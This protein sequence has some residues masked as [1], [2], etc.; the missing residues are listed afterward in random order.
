MLCFGQDVAAA[1]AAAHE[2]GLVHGDLKADNVVISGEPGRAKLLDFGLSIPEEEFGDGELWGTPAYMAPELLAGGARTAAA[3]RFALGVMLFEMATGQLPFGGEDGDE[4]R[5]RARQ[6]SEAPDARELR[7]EL[8]Q[9]I[10]E[11][12]RRLLGRDLPEQ[13]PEAVEVERILRLR[14]RAEEGRRLQLSPVLILFLLVTLAIVLWSEFGAKQSVQDR[15]TVGG[16]SVAPVVSV[17]TWVRSPGSETES[18]QRFRDALAIFLSGDDPG[19]GLLAKVKELE[20]TGTVTVTDGA[21]GS[22]EWGANW[23]SLTGTGTRQ[24]R[25]TGPITLAR[26]VAERV[27]N[28]NAGNRLAEWSAEIPDEAVFRFI[29]GVRATDREDWSA[30]RSA[31]A[32][33]HQI[34]GVFPEASAWEAALWVLEG[35]I[36]NT[37][38]LLSPLGNQRTA[39]AAILNGR[40]EIRVTSPSLRWEQSHPLARYVNLVFAI[41][42]P[43]ISDQELLKKL[44]AEDGIAFPWAAQALAELAWRRGDRAATQDAID[45]ARIL[46]GEDSS[47]DLLRSEHAANLS[48]VDRETALRQFGD[49]LLELPA[50]HP[51]SWLRLPYLLQKRKIESAAN[52]ASAVEEVGESAVTASLI[53]AINDQIELAEKR[54]RSIDDPFDPSLRDRVVA[55]MEALGGDLEAADRSLRR[56]RELDPNRPETELLLRFIHDGPY[57]LTSGREVAADSPLGRFQGALSSLGVARRLRQEGN[58][59]D[60]ERILAGFR[61]VAD[62]LVVFPW[63]EAVFLAWL[64]QIASLAEQSGNDPAKGVEAQ[65]EWR[66]F[67]DVWPVDRAPDSRV[68]RFADELATALQSGPATRD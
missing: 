1:V 62:D 53:L 52:G 28:D 39:P 27:K 30:A 13:R 33:A 23:N 51:A 17:G 18:S 5:V 21:D 14:R 47:S 40:L 19:S 12:I 4:H 10:A 42:D 38:T 34:A 55:A 56:A 67:R 29:D 36:Q 58:P 31:F 22:A 49:R 66:R 35:Q 41:H 54:S 24:E 20:L 45:R 7:P 43:S 59:E 65:R 25:A 8:P 60:A 16:T 9:E 64:E 44:E 48:S 3:D 15:T 50:Q 37:R 61:F 68:G 11:L 2:N 6:L 32:E 57:Q 26:R 46:L 63:P